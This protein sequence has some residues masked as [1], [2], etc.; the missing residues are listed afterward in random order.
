MTITG[1]SSLSKDDIER[2]VKDAEEN[3]AA[4][5][6]RREAAETRNNAEQLVY[7]VE[8]LLTDNAEQLPDDVKTS[9]QADVDALKTALA[10]DDDEALK[11]AFDTLNA[12]QQKLGEALY[13]QQSQAAPEGEA[14]EQPQGEQPSSNDDDVVDAE[15]VDDED[16]KNDRK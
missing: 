4:D 14:G 5:K 7:S 9:V 15:I 13:Q 1:G 11:T 16:D 2:M 6:A 3:A 12:S 8:K 10:G